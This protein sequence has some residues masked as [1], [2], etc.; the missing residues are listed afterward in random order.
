MGLHSCILY[1][2]LGLIA[3]IEVEPPA[4]GTRADAVLA[5][6]LQC[7]AVFAPLAGYF[8][9]L[10]DAVEPATLPVPERKDE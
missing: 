1:L 5:L 10:D 9:A 3:V 2:L 8:S 6:A 4:W 7:A